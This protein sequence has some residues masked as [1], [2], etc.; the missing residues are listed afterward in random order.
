MRVM[1]PGATEASSFQ[2]GAMDGG[3]APDVEPGHLVLQRLHIAGMGVP[4]ARDAHTGQQVDVAV[5]VGV[6]EHRPLAPVEGDAA[7]QGHGLGTGG[8]K[9]GFGLEDRGGSRTRQGELHGDV[10]HAGTPRGRVA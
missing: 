6:P 1:S 9:P 10:G 3:E 7:E 5:P 8:Q 2:L 4:Q